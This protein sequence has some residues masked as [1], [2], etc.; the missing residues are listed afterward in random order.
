MRRLAPFVLFVLA[1]AC[2]ALAIHVNDPNECDENHVSAPSIVL[3]VLAAAFAF[4]SVTVPWFQYVRSD[5][6][7]VRRLEFLVG[8]VGGLVVAGLL[9]LVAYLIV[10]RYRACD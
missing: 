8:L 3:L 2:S 4:A 6:G 10:S 5:G 1:L 9:T 7:R